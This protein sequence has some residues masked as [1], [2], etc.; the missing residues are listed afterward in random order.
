MQ[1]NYEY[2]RAENIREYGEGT[3]HLAFLGR[4]YT[5][6]THFI[7]ELLQ[8]A[9]DAAATKVQF[10]LFLDRLEVR[11]DG[12]VFNKRDVRGVCGVGEGTKAEDLTQIGKFG[13]GFK[14]VYAYTSAPEIH[15]GEEHFRIEHYVRPCQAA[16]QQP[17]EKWTTLF[18]FAFDLPNLEPDTAKR[19]I[20]QRLRKMSGRTLLF[21]REIKEIVYKLPDGTIGTYLREEHSRGISRKVTVIGYNGEQ[22]EDETWLVYE[23][24]VPIP[25]SLG[26]VRI[27]IG[28]KLEQPTSDERIARI[29]DAPLVAYFA[30]EKQTNFGFLIQGPYRTTPARDNVPKDDVW[31][32][33]LI[34]ETAG[35]TISVLQ[36]LK[37]MGLLTISLLEALPIRM[38][39]FPADGMFY[40]IVAAIHT[41]LREQD[42]LPAF[43]GTFI[44]ASKAKLAR[45][46]DLRALLTYD[47]LQ[48]L[49][50]TDEE[51]KWLSGEI[52]EDRTP[53]LRTFLLNELDVEEIDPE[54]FARKVEKSFLDRLDDKWFASFYEFLLK[55][56]ALDVSS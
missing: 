6:R 52:T 35:L 56:E 3:R 39:D 22:E 12:R 25:E 27:E 55:Q 47:Q 16:E 40:P 43:D 41:A 50:Q 8:N 37:A 48:G 13:I 10:D 28:F 7:F 15:S 26:A 17:G 34:K 44:S 21:L 18:I 1:D 29:S 20:A 32:A 9:E 24:P 54:A 38:E 42:L 30:T 31:N 36:D 49:F 14:S 45:G 33:K 51:I 46:A 2:I 19:E 4:L 11:H 23:R 53:A 5:D